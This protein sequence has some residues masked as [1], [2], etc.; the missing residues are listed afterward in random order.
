MGSLEWKKGGPRSLPSL[1]DQWL[2]SIP[3]TRGFRT[4]PHKKTQGE[5]KREEGKTWEKNTRYTSNHQVVGRKRGDY[6][7]I[8]SKTVKVAQQTQELG[9]KKQE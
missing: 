5:R 9:K 3:G 7:G 1:E 4:S 6:L 8:M 2:K